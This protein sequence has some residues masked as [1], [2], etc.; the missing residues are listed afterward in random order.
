MS[1]EVFFLKNQNDIV[2]DL[3]YSDPGKLEILAVLRLS[4]S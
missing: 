1:F 2:L 4:I 3:L